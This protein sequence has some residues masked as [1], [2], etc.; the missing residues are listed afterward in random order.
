MDP[1]GG[2]SPSAPRLDNTSPTPASSQPTA[3]SIGMPAE[4]PATPAVAP[5]PNP[6][7]TINLNESPVPAPAP[8]PA[9]D[10]LLDPTATQSAQPSPAGKPKG[11]KLK[12]ILLI[13]LAI[14][15]AVGLVAG[16]YMVGLANGKTQGRQQAAAEFQAEAA[17]KQTSDND[18]A[19]DKTTDSDAELELG[20]L[21][22]PEYKDET[23]TGAVGEQVESSDGLVLKVTNIERN[24]K[25][26]D[27]NYKLD[28]S[29]ELVKIN[30]LLGNV[31]KEK[32]KD[33]TSF[34]FRLVSSG[35]AQLTP[36]NIAE[37]EGKFDTV[38][39]DPGSQTKGSIVYAVNKDEKPLTFIREQRYRITGEN[40]EVTTRISVVVSE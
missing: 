6:A 36:E 10:P 13:L 9:A 37:Y 26:T 20:E 30:F 2:I 17:A 1:I 5:A 11:N 27:S 23:I 15:L 16:G 40:R 24:F 12:P 35:D 32:P 34:S 7:G 3:P 33:I 22:D 28:A 14:I 18:E 4:V 19:A 39:I 8:I 29:K 31:T 25:T 38:K 21:K